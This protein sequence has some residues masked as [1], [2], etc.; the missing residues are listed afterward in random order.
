MNKSGEFV[1]VII[2]VY[3]EKN[4]INDA[5]LETLE[6]LE[7]DFDKY[8]LIIVDDGSTD[9]TFE[10]ISHYADK[11]KNI[12]V[13]KHANNQ[14]LGS[15][16]YDGFL[17]AA[18]DYLIFNSADLPLSPENIKTLLENNKPFD[19]LNIER[20]KYSGASA[21]RQ[22][23]SLLNK[24]LLHMLFPLNAK[25][26]RDMN[27]TVIIKKQILESVMPR[28]KS[29]GFFMPEM[30]LKAK[31]KKMNV[32]IAQSEYN[33]RHKGKSHFGKIK[34][35]IWSLYDMIYFRLDLNTRRK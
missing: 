14:N 30:L 13:L 5:I 23:V 31:Y 10:I 12:I 3:N 24:I 19:L 15:S 34:D 11:N 9:N 35:I 7:K 27:F 32:K 8:E 17:K 18:G 29:P 1:S 6:V 4:L 33:P 21:W 16:L 22:T 20:I 2:P 25:D 28:S 26:F